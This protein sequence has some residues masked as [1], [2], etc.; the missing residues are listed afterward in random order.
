[1]LGSLA[2]MTKEVEE[3]D[4]KAVAVTANSNKVK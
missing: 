4:S 1:M 2:N 3:K